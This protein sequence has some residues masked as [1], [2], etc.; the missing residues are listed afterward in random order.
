MWMEPPKALV[1][2]QVIAEKRVKQALGT[3]AEILLTAC[4]FCNI[5]LNDALK[6]LEKEDSIKVMDITELVSMSL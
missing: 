1:P 4:P 5:T 2:S 3:G 6:S